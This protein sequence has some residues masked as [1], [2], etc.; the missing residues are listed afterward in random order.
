VNALRLG[1]VSCGYLG[2]SPFAPGTVG[3]LGGVA[4][5]WAL[6][7]TQPFLLWLLVA[8]ALIYVIGRSLGD[9][10]EAHAGK[11]DP[12]FFVLDEVLGYLVTVAWIAPPTPL[13]LV[14]GFCVFRYFDIFK[15]KPA[16]RLEALGGGDGILL[17]DVVAGIY[18]WV[19]LTAA[20][21]LSGDPSLWSLIQP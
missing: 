17:D 20:R 19:V 5:A 14:V 11:K 9:W 13:T 18:A 1:I 8:C 15:P 2:C 6:G 3:T 12:G 16:R 4:L 21:L 7:F 10:A